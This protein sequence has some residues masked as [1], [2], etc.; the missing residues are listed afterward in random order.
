MTKIVENP[1]NGNSKQFSINNL[2][3]K[4]YAKLIRKSKEKSVVHF[5]LHPKGR[6]G[7]IGLYH[8]GGKLAAL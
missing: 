3:K 7:K 2:I 6:C 5:L 1:L 4:N 8:T